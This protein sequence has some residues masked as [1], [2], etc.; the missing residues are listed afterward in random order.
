MLLAALLGCGDAPDPTDGADPPPYTTPPSQ[1]CDPEVCDTDGDGSVAVSYGGTDC[2][3][4]NALVHVRGHEICNA[5]D[6]D[7]DTLTDDADPTLDLLTATHWWSDADMDSF[8]GGDP[9]ARCAA[10]PDTTDAGDDCDD[11]DPN[12]NPGEDEVCNGVDDDCDALTDDADPTLDTTTAT[13]W[14]DDSDGDGHGNAAI[15]VVAC[16]APDR[17]VADDEDCD[18][19]DDTRHTATLWWVDVD[20]DGWG[21]PHLVPIL[22][23]EPQPG[24]VEVSD[25]CDDADPEQHPGAVWYRDLDQDGF[26]DAEFWVAQCSRPVG[27]AVEATDCDDL[28]PRASPAVTWYSDNDGDSFGDPVL[29]SPACP[30]VGPLVDDDTDC[31]DA[32]AAVFPGAAEM[33]NFDDDDCDRKIDEGFPVTDW[34]EDVDEDG[35]GD[36]SVQVAACA[37]PLGFVEASGD[38][39]VAE[40]TIYPGAPEDCDDPDLDCDGLA[41]PLAFDV[42]TVV[43]TVLRSTS[44]APVDMDADGDVDVVWTDATDVR[45]ASNLGSGAFV[46]STLLDNTFSAPLG[47]RLA[48]LDG[49]TDTDLLW[50]SSSVDDAVLWMENRGGGT[51]GPAQIVGDEVDGPLAPAADDVDLDGDIDVVT[52]ASD[53]A[54]LVWFENLGVGSFA[55]AAIVNDTLDAPTAVVT[56]DVD[57]DGDPDVVAASEVGEVLVWIENLGDGVFGPAIEFD[58][59]AA[60][61]TALLAADTDGDDDLDVV[62]CSRTDEAIAAFE[63][64]GGAFGPRTV[65]V[66]L[67]AGPASVAVHV[68]DLDGDGDG[69]LLAAS[70]AG[71]TLHWLE[72]L[73]GGA[74]APPRGVAERLYS[75]WLNAADIDGDGAVDVLA[76]S[77]AAAPARIDWYPGDVCE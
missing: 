44:G 7:C 12:V 23:C 58:T 75:V 74:F 53:G 77:S 42:P 43:R 5:I 6:D 68:A 51:Y 35:F 38:C 28:N 40:A 56:L 47:L 3:D 41:P 11:A 29:P 71:E 16:T 72:Q 18:P 45:W 62:A 10:P 54:G 15:S 67:G 57:L 64:L 21:S 48:D 34:Y 46:T 70:S 55:D 66:D 14:Y 25:D 17:F 60:D 8:G 36:A 31:D 59:A 33:C 50:V 49:D 52:G 37:P 13:T 26:G 69:D 9:V 65:L 27:Y 39:D 30:V 32:A 76:A 73:G 22:T 19:Y 63:N 20:G 4:T 1:T 2:D 24:R 61:V